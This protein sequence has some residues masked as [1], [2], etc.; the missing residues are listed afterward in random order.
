[1]TSGSTPCRVQVQESS[2][3]TSIRTEQTC[4]PG[5]QP[6]LAE[7]P[8]SQGGSVGRGQSWGEILQ[9]RRFWT[10]RHV[11]ST[12]KLCEGRL[13]LLSLLGMAGSSAQNVSSMSMG[14]EP[15]SP[16]S[17][18][19]VSALGRSL[20]LFLVLDRLVAALTSTGIYLIPRE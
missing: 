4:S 6:S 3:S 2:Q 13:T 18:S 1:M 12:K 11:R 19:L 9:C 8:H 16:C 20:A 7:R 15:V 10:G 14:W 17:I 5:M